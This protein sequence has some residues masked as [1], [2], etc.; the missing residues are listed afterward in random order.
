MEKR[1]IRLCFIALVFPGLLHAQEA[2]VFPLQPGAVFPEPSQRSLQNIEAIPTTT[3]T[4]PV[5]GHVVQVP[6]V[7]TLMRGK[8]GDEPLRW[9]MHAASRDADMAPL[10][11]KNRVNWQADI[12]M[13]PDCGLALP[14]DK[15]S[16]PVPPE[17]AE[18]VMET[19]KPNL[20]A[21]QKTVL[22]KRAS[23]MSENQII[24]FFNRQ[25]AIPDIV[26]TEHY[27][28]YAVA[29]SLPLLE[30][31]EA[32]WLAAWSLRRES[33][34]HGKGEFFAKYQNAVEAML[35]KN[36]NASQS[37]RM[38]A[39]RRLLGKT[40]AGK[41]RVPYAEQL[42]A[43]LLL[44]NEMFHR[45]LYKDG[46]A[47]LGE[48]HK[49]AQDRFLKPDQDPLWPFTSKNAARSVRLNELETIRT[50]AENEL[51]VKMDQIRLEQELLGDAADLVREAI[52]AG[53][54]TDC[55]HALYYAYLVGEFLR[56]HE[57]FPLAA[58]WF[59]NLINLAQ[60]DTPVA[61]AA[62]RQLALLQEQAGDM[63]LLAALGQN[64][65]MFE[66]L[67]E[68]CARP[69]PAAPTAH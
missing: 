14:V 49:R 23:S 51:A 1:L 53:E 34:S 46:L 9:R 18:W 30:Q 38:D 59:K 39:L 7:D 40:R 54:I 29:A 2:G 55:E 37:A 42:A 68:I 47:L 24:E 6:L 15:F 56:R 4:C 64:G 28:I 3:A 22:G 20:R 43:R 10:P 32:T 19:L 44:A 8:N 21:M 25:E 66:K 45:G 11:A 61:D 17:I 65:E 33:A 48:I 31:A 52:L 63:N 5:C 67:R 57:E 26:R 13:C 62:R 35:D 27:R 16:Q 69:E 12:I 41:D 58:E 36:A 60:P 50:D